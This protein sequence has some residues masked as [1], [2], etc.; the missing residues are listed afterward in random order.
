VDVILY[1]GENNTSPKALISTCQKSF[2]FLFSGFE[3]F[4]NIG[5]PGVESPREKK[6]LEK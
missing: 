2:F 4:P 6:Q 5:E 1:D 3:R